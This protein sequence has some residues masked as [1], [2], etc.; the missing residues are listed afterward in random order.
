MMRRPV[1]CLLPLRVATEELKHCLAPALEE[2][3]ILVFCAMLFGFKGA[4]LIMGRL[5]A[6]LARLWQSMIMRDGELQLYMDDPLFAIIGP[7]GSRRGVLAML[8]YTAAAM[9]IQLAF[10][11]GE[12]GLRIC[13]I[14]VQLEIVANRALLLLTV[15]EKVVN[16]LL[17]KMKE[18]KGK[19]KGMIAFQDLRASTGKLSWV[20]G[21]V[22]RIR[23]TVSILYA[24]VASAEMDD[25]SGE[26][27]TRAA[28]RKDQRPKVGLVPPK[29][30]ELP[31]RGCSTSWS[32]VKPQPEF[33]VVAD[34]SPLGVGAILAVADA[35]QTAFPNVGGAQGRGHEGSGGV[36]GTP[37]WQ[38][39]LAGATGSLGIGAGDTTVAI[40]AARHR[41]SHQVRLGGGAGHGE[42]VGGKLAG[43]ELPG[44]VL[45]MEP[46]SR[47][48][49]RAQRASPCR[50]LKHRG[51][52]VKQTSEAIRHRDT[53][54]TSRAQGEG[55]HHRL[56]FVVPHSV[57]W[58]VGTVGSE[59]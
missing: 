5:S 12:R 47:G 31:G 13:W 24:V 18:W 53:S 4:P 9:G 54:C 48:N 40:Q 37:V 26:E 46:Q 21:I 28:S 41:R 51:R 17:A 23:L 58:R 36:S 16:E 52:L 57:T 44:R 25:R 33:L 39:R 22:P 27:F 14:G 43:A 29:R 56:G 7:K 32:M 11:N 2:D 15:P 55:H 19:G 8:L 35:S 30:V 1:G 50:C 20:A 45:G 34:A 38:V 6:A 59:L 42:K 10:R 3:E 49:L